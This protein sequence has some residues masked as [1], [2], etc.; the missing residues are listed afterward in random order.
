[1][2]DSREG[3]AQFV[4]RHAY[5]ISILINQMSN[6]AVRVLRQ[7]AAIQNARGEQPV[8]VAVRP[9]CLGLP[10][11]TDVEAILRRRLRPQRR[12]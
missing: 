1:M 7:D 2:G 5:L 9:R 11:L 12:V 8:S 3:Y 10:Q 6:T 4:R